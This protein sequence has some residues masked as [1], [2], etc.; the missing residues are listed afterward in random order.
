VALDKTVF[1]DFGDMKDLDLT[2]AIH[3]Y[4]HNVFNY[5]RND[6]GLNMHRSYGYLVNVVVGRIVCDWWENV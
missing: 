6:S 5:F 1:D 4:C 3:D 2:D